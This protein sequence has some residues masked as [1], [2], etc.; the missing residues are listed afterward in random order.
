MSEAPSLEVQGLVKHFP[1]HRGLLQRRSGAVRELF[2][3]PLH[4][5]TEG[6]LAAMPR[7]EGETRRLPAIPGSIPDPDEPIPG[8]RFSPRC[9]EALD[10]CRVHAPALLAAGGGRF[11]RCPPRVARAAP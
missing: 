8:C 9:A 7:L 10:S 4:P 6:L 5:Y 3:R 11:A 2:R 1:I